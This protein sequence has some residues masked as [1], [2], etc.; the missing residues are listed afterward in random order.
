MKLL[1]ELLLKR[2]FCL[3]LVNNYSMKVHHVDYL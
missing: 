1:I 2:M 3:Y